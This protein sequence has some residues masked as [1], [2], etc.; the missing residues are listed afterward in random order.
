MK[1]AKKFRFS[2]SLTRYVNERFR[3][4]SRNTVQGHCCHFLLPFNLLL[5][6][7][8]KFSHVFTCNLNN[9]ATLLFLSPLCK[10]LSQFENKTNYSTSLWPSRGGEGPDH[11]RLKFKK[12][13][14]CTNR[15]GKK[16]PLTS[17]FESCDFGNAYD[18]WMQ[19]TSAKSK[20]RYLNFL[21]LT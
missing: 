13:K 20:A 5:S 10:W 11:R 4:T 3:D 16:V 15:I 9:D 2:F 21:N 19:Q 14:S 8:L 1:H 6:L 7:L 17:L 12:T 18:R